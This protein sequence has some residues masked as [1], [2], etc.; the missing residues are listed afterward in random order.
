MRLLHVDTTCTISCV[1]VCVCVW[2]MYCVIRI[3][4]V[5]YRHSASIDNFVS[6]SGNGSGDTRPCCEIDNVNAGLCWAAPSIYRLVCTE[7]KLQKNQSLH[8]SCVT[9]CVKNIQVIIRATPV[10]LCGSPWLLGAV[11]RNGCPSSTLRLSVMSGP[12]GPEWKLT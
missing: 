9:G 1:C 2:W 7:T 4:S 6:Q 3:R 5:R 10:L 11:L 8:V 12:V